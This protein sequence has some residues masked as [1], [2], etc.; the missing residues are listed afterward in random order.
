MRTE[1]F[2][3]QVGGALY[4]VWRK[5]EGPL[6]GYLAGLGGLT[7]WTPFLERLAQHR[8]VIVPSLPGFPGGGTGHV[9]LDTHLDWILAV[10][11][12]ICTAGLEGA[13]FVAGNIGA[14]LICEIAA[15]W[16]S[17]IGRLSLIAPHGLYL[18]AY[19]PTDIWAQAPGRLGQLICACPENWLEQRTPPDGTYD[20]IEWALEQSRANEA[21]ARIFWPLG[22]TDLAKRLPR[23]T[24]ATQLLWGDRD[25]VLPVHYASV[26]KNLI[27][28]P[29]VIELIEGA[30]HLAELDQPALVAEYV[31]RWSAK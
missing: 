6:L 11:D 13:D 9:A 7:R 12:L 18:E 24:A 17:A 16:P 1:E 25:E 8:T 23:I 27:A 5:G 29:A 19:P 14:S 22:A 3:V 10:Y 2:C 21:V 4:R 20:S 26:F 15:L 30:G 31:L 28:G